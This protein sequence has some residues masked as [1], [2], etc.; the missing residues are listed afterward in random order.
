M[1]WRLEFYNARQRRLAPYTI[2]APLPA[3]AVAA[4]WDALRAQHPERRQ[5]GVLSLLERAERASADDRN[6]WVLYRIVADQIPASARA[7][8]A[9]APIA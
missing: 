6:G 5:R 4:G 2:D 7:D 3:A 1:T 9:V 8:A